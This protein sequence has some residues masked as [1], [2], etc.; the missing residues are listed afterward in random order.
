MWSSGIR[1][2]NLGKLRSE[3]W[4]D[5]PR[6]PHL[7]C[8]LTRPYKVLNRRIG[9]KRSHWLR[10]YVIR[11]GSLNNHFLHGGLYG[12][13]VKLSIKKVFNINNLDEIVAVLS[14]KTKKSL[15]DEA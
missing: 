3:E 15:I 8:H 13:S 5:L 2:T 10:V 4:A 12:G 9:H 11:F 7:K 1:K 14:D 6:T